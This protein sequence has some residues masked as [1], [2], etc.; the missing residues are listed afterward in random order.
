MTALSGAAV[1]S[2]REW[3]LQDSATLLAPVH[4]I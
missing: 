2:W 1:A 4:V 3:E